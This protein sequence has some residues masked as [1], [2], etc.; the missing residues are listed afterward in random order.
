LLPNRLVKWVKLEK[1]TIYSVRVFERMPGSNDDEI[2]RLA[3]FFGGEEA[4]SVVR[5][6]ALA[7]TTTD[8]VIATQANVR[9][10]TARKVLYKLYDHALVTVIRSRDENTG[11]FIYHWR[12]QRDQIDAFVRSRKKK[13]LEKIRQRLEHEKAHSFFMCK[14]CLTIRMTFEDAMESAFRC[15]GCNDQLISEDNSKTIEV[16]EESARKLESELSERPIAFANTRF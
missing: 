14:G 5:A 2:A 15:S 9:L 13:A 12:L 4:L 11:W 3:S 6:L 7:G 1:C 8:D 10:N 16:L